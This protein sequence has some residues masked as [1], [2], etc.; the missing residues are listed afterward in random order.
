MAFKQASVTLFIKEVLKEKGIPQK[1]LQ[2]ALGVT[3]ATISY[4]VNGK[5]NPSLE[6]LQ[7]IAEFLGVPVWRLLTSPEEFRATT[8]KSDF[9]AFVRSNGVSYLANTLQ[10]LKAIVAQLEGE[11]V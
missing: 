1:A 6:T 11:Q 7:K 2:E 3:Q 10:D 4:I 5:T 9:A 8:Q